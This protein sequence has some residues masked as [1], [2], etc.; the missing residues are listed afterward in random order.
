MKLYKCEYPNCEN[1]SKIRS[2]IKNKDSEYYGLSVCNYHA[3]QHRLKVVSEQT[4]RTQKVRKE[5][6]KDY[7]EFYKKHCKIA[8]RKHCLECGSKLQ[9]TSSEI[10]HIIRKSSNPELS[11]LDDNILYLCTDCHNIFDTSLERRSQ[12]KCFQQ[13]VEQ[14]KLMQ[15]KVENNSSEVWHYIKILG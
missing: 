2:K 11:V 3:S 6:R 13:S 4:R 12:M 1:L 10:A 5:Q 14:Y 7:P 15:D 9:G 8:V